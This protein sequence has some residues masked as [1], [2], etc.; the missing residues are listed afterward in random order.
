MRFII[1]MLFIALFCVPAMAARP[2]REQPVSELPKWQDFSARQ[3]RSL[4]ALGACLQDKT[5]CASEEIVRW[6]KLVED[7]TPQN[8]LRQ[9]ITVNRWFNRLPYKYDEYAYETLDYWADTAELLL[10]KG[11]CE[12]YALSKYYT[13]RQL[14]FTPDELKITVVYDSYNYTNHAVLMVY[15][16]GTRYMLDINAD[17][18]NPEDL[19]LR[20]KPLYAFNEKTAWF[21]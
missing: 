17:D 14:G 8:K 13:L 11:D 5:Q 10:K 21:Y 18:M 1:S 19:G 3:E 2:A 9:M 12:D 16:G 15:T 20:Y 7:L 6:T 4:E